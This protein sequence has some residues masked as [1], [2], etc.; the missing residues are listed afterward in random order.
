MKTERTKHLINSNGQTNRLWNSESESGFGTSFC[1]SL[2]HIRVIQFVIKIDQLLINVHTWPT[3]FCLIHSNFINEIKTLKSLSIK[4]VWMIAHRLPCT[5]KRIIAAIKHL[6]PIKSFFRVSPDFWKIQSKLNFDS[7]KHCF[8]RKICVSSPLKRLWFSA[9]QT[10]FAQSS[11]PI[12]VG[13][14][15]NLE[16]S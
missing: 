6:E 9:G 10:L 13:D 5:R 4:V 11:G 7:M 1:F 8:D 14:L 15:L 2:T 12:K 3:N 16:L